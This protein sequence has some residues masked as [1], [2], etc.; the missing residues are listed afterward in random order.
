[1]L[2]VINPSTTQTLEKQIK[3]AEKATLMVVPGD[4]MPK[5]PA[6]PSNTQASSLSKG[7]IVGIVVGVAVLVALCGAL[8]YFV[9]RT[10]SLKE[11]MKQRDAAVTTASGTPGPEHTGIPGSMP[12][13]LAVYSVYSPNTGLVEH[14]TLP[15]RYGDEYREWRGSSDHLGHTSM[16]PQE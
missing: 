14:E 3:A 2:G 6:S 13:S 12:N 7:A 5:E 4:P 8:F 15:P 9:G 1:M 10:R 16:A 11:S